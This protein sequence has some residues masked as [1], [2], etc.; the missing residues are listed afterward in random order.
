MAEVAGS[1]TEQTGEGSPVADPTVVLD[2]VH[3]TYRVYQDR[4][5]R[6]RELVAGRFKTRAHREIHAV[7][8]VSF[9]AYEG[10]AIGVIGSNG[11][12]K[13]TLMQAIAGLLPATKGAVYARSQ[14]TLLGVGSALQRNVSGRRNII[15]GGLALGMSRKQVEEQVE[16]IIDFSGLREAIDLPL[17][18]YSSGM[19][20]RLHFAIATSVIP[21]I[22]LVDEALAVGDEDFH[23]RS[24]KRIEAL[25]SK[26][27]TIFL[28]THSLNQVKETCSRAIWLEDGRL[29]EDGDPPK[30][31]KAYKASLKA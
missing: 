21:E 23:R 22:L 14:P 30:V 29:Q 20:A 3:V 24:D 6:L 28:V 12:G 26:A 19:K 16:E 25:R 17:R 2:D 13:S 10:E 11:S 4:R 5:P 9:T 31:I 8:G 1:V 18:T 7:K 27:G 15:L